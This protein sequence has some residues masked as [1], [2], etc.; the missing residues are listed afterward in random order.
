[1]SKLKRTHDSTAPTNPFEDA[2]ATPPVLTG[3]RS[4]PCHSKHHHTTTYRSFDGQGEQLSARYAAD[5]DELQPANLSHLHTGASSS[6]FDVV[7]HGCQVVSVAVHR[8]TAAASCKIFHP[9]RLG[10]IIVKGTST[11]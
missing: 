2:P 10:Y 5:A 4:A 8:A 6:Y 3:P 9:G 7:A 11:R 1:M